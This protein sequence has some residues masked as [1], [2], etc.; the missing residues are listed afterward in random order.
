[1]RVKLLLLLLLLLLP[2]VSPK[3]QSKLMCLISAT[4]SARINPRGEGMSISHRLVDE[5]GLQRK[6]GRSLSNSDKC[7]RPP[8]RLTAPRAFSTE[9]HQ[10]S[11]SSSA[12]IA[13]ICS[14][15][16]GCFAALI[17]L[18]SSSLFLTPKMTVSTPSIASAY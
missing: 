18:S 10:E 6:T 12:S 13:S 7:C 14:A 4:V 9:S 16:S 8:Q 2:L 15:V 17:V 11:L 5:G 1:M 3:L